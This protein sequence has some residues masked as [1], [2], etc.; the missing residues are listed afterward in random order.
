MNAVIVALLPDGETGSRDANACGT[1]CGWGFTWVQA[2]CGE[3][4]PGPDCVA[5]AGV[6][7]AW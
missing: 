7:V 6:G 2:V 3:L 4:K 1:C 5:C